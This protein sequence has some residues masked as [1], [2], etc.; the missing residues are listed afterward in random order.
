MA[1]QDWA[2][3]VKGGCKLCSLYISLCHPLF[4]IALGN[5]K[6]CIA[7]DFI[8]FTMA[9]EITDERIN[10]TNEESPMETASI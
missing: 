5:I 3:G 1:L 8:G 10:A 7:E 6:C 9:T 4:K 2:M